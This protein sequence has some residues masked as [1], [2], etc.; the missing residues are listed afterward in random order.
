MRISYPTLVGVLLSMTALSGCKTVNEAML[1]AENAAVEQAETME[2]QSES[3]TETSDVEKI[4][5]E[6]GDVVGVEDVTASEDRSE[7]IAE[8]PVNAKVDY[9]LVE[10]YQRALET[11]PEF[12]AAKERKEAAEMALPAAWAELFPR[13][14]FSWEDSTTHLNVIESQNTV[15]NGGKADYKSWTRLWSLEAPIV[16][17]QKFVGLSQARA[18]DKL[19]MADYEAKRQELTVRVVKEYLAVLAAEENKRLA[20][21]ELK[22]SEKQLEQVQ[23]RYDS[24]LVS[25]NDVYEIEARVAQLKAEAIETK[26]NL[27]DSKEALFVL[28]GIRNVP[29]KDVTRDIPI[30]ALEPSNVEDWAARAEMQNPKIVASQLELTVADREVARRYAAHLPNVSM[31]LQDS[32]EDTDD[33]I[34]G[35]GGK[36]HEKK[37]TMQLRVPLFDARVFPSG[38]EA[39]YLKR[40]AAADL[41]TVKRSVDRET[42]RYFDQV[43]TGADRLAALKKAVAF[44]QSALDENQS[45]YESNLK[46]IV[47]VLDAR[48]ELYRAERDLIEG[49][50][51]YVYATLNLR[52]SA[53]AVS[54]ADVYWLSDLMAALPA[55]K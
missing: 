4:D 15:F 37:A 6:K 54:Q 26:N 52:A 32:Y 3:M 22:S 53:G 24:G 14:T 20:D 40:A 5:S 38:R 29:L 43:T 33:T 1:E 9:N 13:L 36:I 55:A 28:T 46:D 41:E 17:F 42:R 7:V 21:E 10:L 49:W 51:D 11:S 31:T 25:R 39:Q 12:R 27:H 50:L 2:T 47:D 44:R 18:S 45:A 16:D 35:G 30:Q 48:S 23:G 8:L 34:Y 19:A